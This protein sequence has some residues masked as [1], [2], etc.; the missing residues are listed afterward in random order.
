LG[1][2]EVIAELC[3]LGKPENVAGMA[4]Y[5]IRSRRVLGVPTPTLRAMAKRI[6]RHHA[7]AQE[8][9][10]T[11][12]LEA[13]VIAS[14]IA[15]PKLVTEELMESWAA[16]FDCWALCDGACCVLFDKTRF[17]WKKAIEWS[18]RDE[19]YGKR[20]AYAIMAALAVHDKVAPD[21][22]YLRFLPVIRRGAT[23]ERNFV[24]KAVNWAL[25]QIGKRNRALNR[26]AIAEARKIREL[27]TRSARWIAADALRELESVAVQNRLKTAPGRGLRN[28]VHKP[29]P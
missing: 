14:L 9:W 24:R 4:R 25:R 29:R 21:A 12:I 20:G 16:D 19:E 15:D 26:A 22:K 8:L 3:A 13:R 27:N 11:G 10:Q 6:G 5:G 17:A 7:L 23:D 18:R 1:A 28:A 2:E